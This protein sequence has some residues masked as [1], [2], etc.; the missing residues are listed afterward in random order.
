M[1]RIDAVTGMRGVA[2]MLVV[3]FHAVLV[4]WLAQLALGWR[5]DAFEHPLSAG[6]FGAG[7]VGVDFFFVL[8][9]FLL[10]TPLLQPR[11]DAPEGYRVFAAKRLLRIAP[12][13]YASF[14]VVYALAGWSG[15]PAFSFTLESVLV[16]ILYLHNFFVE[17][18][19]G[20]NGVAWT[21]AVEL[22]FYLLLP[23]LVLPFRRW[24]AWPALPFAAAALAWD[25]WAFDPSDPVR[26]RFLTFQF[27][28]FLAHFAFGIAAADLLR[29]GWRPP[30]PDV[31]ATIA[32]V[33]L[34]VLPALALGYT[35]QF[36]ALDV[37]AYHV[38]LRPAAGLA[39]AVGIVCALQEGSRI[40]R[41]LAV[42]PLLWLGELS[43]S[44]Y[45]VHLAAGGVYLVSGAH[46][47]FSHGLPFFMLLMTATSLL[48]AVG[49]YV[50]VERPSLRLKDHIV[51][52][53]RGGADA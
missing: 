27:P 40:G 20:L 35:R 39:F 53:L 10:A 6:F 4:F 9:G 23:I 49:L 46:W 32:I 13:Y 21:L 28:A 15:N 41:L 37:T 3:G 33:L 18:Q 12:P 19:F 31:L 48:V 29:R 8:S 30:A 1:G 38:Y 17:H 51:R 34:V 5:A 42:R 7:W 2:S 11:P 26:T 36:E 43:Y 50:A 47:A 52:R 24:G 16:H 44:I 45:L 25:A 22:Q 14:L